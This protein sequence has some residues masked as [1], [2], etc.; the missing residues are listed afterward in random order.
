VESAGE[1][2]AAGRVAA[3]RWLHG[4]HSGI[5]RVGRVAGRERVAGGEFDR[6]AVV[7]ARVQP[8]GSAGRVGVERE[9]GLAAGEQ[10]GN[11]GDGSRLWT[12]TL[13]FALRY[14]A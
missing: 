14:A 8:L 6:R 12:D 2:L 7:A 5:G 1:P 3:A 4:H 9:D 10:S 11:V 13:P